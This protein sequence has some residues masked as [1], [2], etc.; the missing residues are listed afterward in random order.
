MVKWKKVSYT[1]ELGE[2]E[3]INEDF[4]YGA[5]SKEKRSNLDMLRAAYRNGKLQTLTDSKWRDLDNTDSWKTDT[6]EKIQKAIKSN[7]RSSGKRS[8]ENVLK[9]FLTG[10]VRAPIVLS[11]NN[12]KNMSLI[13]GNTR[14][15]VAR[16]LGIK[17]DVVVVDLNDW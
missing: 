17:P 5:T 7:A 13:A 3:R 16:M 15:M 6:L 9:E 11:F 8:I 2:F 10:S 4:S 12:G 14:L 1:D